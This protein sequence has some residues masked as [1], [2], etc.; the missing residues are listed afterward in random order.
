MWNI[1]RTSCAALVF[2]IHAR[3]HR[4]KEQ[5]EKKIARKYNTTRTHAQDAHKARTSAGSVGDGEE[6]LRSG[7]LGIRRFRGPCSFL[8]QQHELSSTERLPGC[9]WTFSDWRKR[10]R[11][12]PS[13]SRWARDVTTRVAPSSKPPAMLPPFGWKF[14]RT[15]LTLNYLYMGSLSP[16]PD[17]RKNK[18][19]ICFFFH[20]HT[21]I[22][23]GVEGEKRC[24]DD[25]VK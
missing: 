22:Q 15:Y 20:T 5:Q 10:L 21:Q 8:Q 13:A 24:G 18:S 25:E 4:C 16:P 2:G 7:A 1:G 19:I 23:K 6:D 9:H 17:K 14:A 12:A 11:C 3:H